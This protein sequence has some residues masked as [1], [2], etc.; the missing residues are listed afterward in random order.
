MR[1]LFLILVMVFGWT[2]NADFDAGGPASAKVI[3]RGLASPVIPISPEMASCLKFF[4]P[5]H[6]EAWLGQTLSNRPAAI[7]DTD[8]HQGRE[9]LVE[10]FRSTDDE[11][12]RRAIQNL[13]QRINQRNPSG[14][15]EGTSGSGDARTI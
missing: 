2:V 10:S 14:Q 15:Q 4:A 8:L 13:L 7:S 5:A 6:C 1:L 9:Q 11:A 3:E 12:E